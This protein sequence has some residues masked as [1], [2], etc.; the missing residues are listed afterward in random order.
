MKHSTTGDVAAVAFIVIVALGNI[1]FIA[2]A[3]R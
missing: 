1:L 3:W 2:L